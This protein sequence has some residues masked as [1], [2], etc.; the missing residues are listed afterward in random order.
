MPGASR[1]VGRFPSTFIPGQPPRPVS[2][3]SGYVSTLHRRF[4]CVRLSGSHLTAAHGGMR[5]FDGASAA[6]CHGLGSVVWY[7]NTYHRAGSFIPP[8]RAVLRQNLRQEPYAVMLHV[9]ICAGGGRQLPSLPRPAVPSADFAAA[10]TIRVGENTP[11]PA[12]PARRPPVARTAAAADAA[13][14]VARSR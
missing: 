2:T 14:L 7:A 9:R 13:S 6:D 5:C 3:P 8:L 10:Y 12:R 11:A 4:T 1:A